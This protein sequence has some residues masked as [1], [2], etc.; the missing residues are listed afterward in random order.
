[1]EPCALGPNP[2]RG[3][4]QEVVKFR[5]LLGCETLGCGAAS[6]SAVD[7]A[8][9]DERERR[10][11]KGG[12]TMKWT[13]KFAVKFAFVAV[14]ALAG[15]LWPGPSVAVEV[16]PKVIEAIAPTYPKS[17][18][19]DLKEGWVYLNLHVTADGKVAGATVAKSYPEGVFDEAAL[20][21]AKT[22]KF[23]PKLIGGV[24]H[25]ELRHPFSFTFYMKMPRGVQ[26]ESY[27]DFRDTLNALRNSDVEK[28]EQRIQSLRVRYEKEAFNLTEIARYYQLE[29]LLAIE[30]GD[31]VRA[32]DFIDL[33]LRLSRYLDNKNV[34]DN[35]HFQMIV[36]FL[37]VNQFDN[38]VDY[39]DA[40]RKKSQMKIAEESV[41]AIEDLRAQGY[42]RGRQFEITTY[43]EE[44]EDLKKSTSSNERVKEVE[45]VPDFKAPPV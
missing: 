17:A 32:A 25:E 18:K 43:G 8:P 24:P 39:Y 19:T 16:P 41:K 14:A 42:G 15:L 22:F 11:T 13:G 38:G 9:G 44:I 23:V 36:A 10:H 1:M 34:V 6:P 12:I 3:R 28:A 4:G 5:W 2:W 29:G 31:Y 40:W 21:A 7:C 37:G 33:S 35:L 27:K 30:K 45:T 26:K 20:N